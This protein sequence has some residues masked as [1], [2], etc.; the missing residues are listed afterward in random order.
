M[1]TMTATRTDHAAEALRLL[2]AALA[3][4]DRWLDTRHPTVSDTTPEPPRDRR[5]CIELAA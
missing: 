5:T 3:D 1:T 2:D 4:N